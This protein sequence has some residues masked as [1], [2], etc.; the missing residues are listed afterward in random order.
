MPILIL[1]GIAGPGYLCALLYNETF[2]RF[3]PKVEEMSEEEELEAA[4][5]KIDDTTS[6]NEDQ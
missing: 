2:K 6:D 3:E 1:L 4:I 5:R